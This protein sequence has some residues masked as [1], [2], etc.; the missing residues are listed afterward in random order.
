MV[1][2]I[3]H[4]FLLGLCLLVTL[5]CVVGTIFPLRFGPYPSD[6]R[7]RSVTTFFVF[8]NH[9]SFEVYFLTHPL[10]PRAPGNYARFHLAGEDIEY[11]DILYGWGFYYKH[12]DYVINSSNLVRARGYSFTI[13]YWM[14]GLVFLF[15]TA[16][17][18]FPV[19]R[20]FRRRLRVDA[21]SR[22]CPRCQYDLRGHKPGE[23]CPEC[24]V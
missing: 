18:C 15:F 9:H 2:R 22:P 21:Q 19:V 14:L 11:I 24:G 17:L 23:A 8:S 13:P 10:T 5:A 12:F 3:L 4:A 1:R 7:D 20:R 6:Y 16:L